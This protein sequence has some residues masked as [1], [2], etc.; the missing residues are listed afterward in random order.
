MD[1]APPKILFGAGTHASGNQYFAIVDCF[2]HPAM[3]VLRFWAKA[4]WMILMF[5][6]VWLTGK[7]RVAQLIAHFTIYYLAILHGHDHIVSRP[8]EMLANV[9]PII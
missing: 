4:M 2:N 5:L 7:M 6:V 3:P 1:S 8:P 9:V